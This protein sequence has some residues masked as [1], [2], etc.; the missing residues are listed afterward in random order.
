MKIRSLFE[1]D[2]FRPINGVV[3]AEQQ[4]DAVIWQELEEY[5]VTREL[6]RH[7]RDFFDA[8]VQALRRADDPAIAGN[9]GVWISG[10]FG[11]GK[12]HFLKILSYLLQNR[13]AR[14]DSDGTRRR[15]V[16]FFRDKIADQKL[17]ADILTA[18]NTD[19]D[20]ILFN[21]DS[22]A[23][24]QDGDDAILG[25]FW[26]VFNEMRG[27][28]GEIPYIAAMEE[29]LDG[30][31][32]YD[33]FQQ[34]FQELSGCSWQE[35]RDAFHF[36]RDPLIGALA[37]TLGMTQESAAKWFDDEG[38]SFVASIDNFAKSVAAYIQK[39]GGQRRVIFLVDEVGQFIGSDTRRM[40][41]LQTITENLGTHCRGRAWVIVTSQADIE[42]VLGEVKASKAN[43]FSKIQGR[44]KTRLSLSSSNTDEVIR[45]RLLRKTDA[46]REAL[47]PLYQ[48]KKD[49]LNNQLS[50][51]GDCA[52][53][54]N[55]ASETDFVST[56]PFAPYH[57]QL[58]QKVFE[59]IRKAGA[60]G[61]H[62]S[63]GERSMLDAF[64]SA[65]R[66]VAG[67]EIG[68][69]VPLDAFYPSI[70]SFL[71]TVVKATIDRAAENP[72]LVQPLDSRVLKTLFLIRYVEL[73]KP[74]VDNLV[75]LFVDKV[76]TDRLALKR[77]LQESLQRL[78]KETLINR[79][80]EL[81]YFLTNEERDISRE[82]KREPV[83]AAEQRALLQTLFFD[84]ILKGQTKFRMKDFRRDYEF[85]R[86][87][88]GHPH[89][90]RGEQ[91]MAVEIITQF[92]DD[93]PSLDAARCVLYSSP[94]PGR[95][96]FK[97]A[98]DPLLD[99]E[100]TIWCQTD[101]YI[102]GPKG[103]ADTPVQKRILRERQD[104]NVDRR[105]RLQRRLEK[106]LLQADVYSAGKALSLT[107]QAR[108][109]AKNLLESAFD[110]LVRNLYNEF[111][112]LRSLQ[113]S[114]EKC[115]A[116]IRSVMLS[117]TVGQHALLESLGQVN[118]EA[119][120]A[121][122]DHLRMQSGAVLSL[123]DLQNRFSRKPFGWPEWE[124]VLLVA[125]LYMAGSVNLVLGTAETDNMPPQALLEQLLKTQ[126][127]KTLCITLR[128]KP[129]EA[130]IRKLRALYQE[131]SGK[132]AGN[133]PDEA[134]RD[135]RDLLAQWQRPLGGYADL[136]ASGQYPGAALLEDCR[137][138][139]APLC[140]VRDDA[141]FAR[142]IGKKAD[143][144]RD[145]REDLD[146]LRD[147]FQT[148]KPVWER[149]LAALN[150]YQSSRSSLQKDAQAAEALKKLESIRS[151][152]EP[153][154]LIKDIDGLLA[155]IKEVAA[156]QLAG[157]RQK[158]LDDV[159]GCLAAVRDRLDSLKA[160]DAD[161]NRILHPLQ[162]L[163]Q[164]VTAARTPEEVAY[165]M[166]ELGEQRDKAEEEL[167]ALVHP[168][169]TGTPG[170]DGAPQPKPRRHVKVAQLV[171]H[172]TL[173]NAEDV[174][175]FI[176]ELKVQ[177]LAR[178]DDSTRL[179]VE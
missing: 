29:Y 19:T 153:Y 4:D 157:A 3:K 59:S 23:N 69:L 102:K 159:D 10:F 47:A 16:D 131:L 110:Y 37:H 147:F 15:A 139:L 109:S 40:L 128:H 56:Y 11:S 174:E 43:D 135:F 31:G 49:I 167:D 178:L 98:E 151:Y 33:A 116:E 62:L 93:F 5:V 162:S 133:T 134:V 85:A 100:V 177:L 34:K 26:R 179:V 97:L 9:M 89:A 66:S 18:G 60:T 143:V 165:I 13:E 20:V 88:D 21:I 54:K 95:L 61:S 32:C 67:G 138:V 48:A 63:R 64:Q 68:A 1:K 28:H 129:A 156:A 71:D 81:Y 80:G 170:Q 149:L 121:V 163:R 152:Q 35:N 161:R 104:E 146:T 96:L 2:V 122:E 107:S 84:E 106:L 75:T 142:D 175:R 12:S 86:L 73:I 25:V 113:D 173:E 45:Y 72:G 114:E 76:D 108:S 172:R 154:N 94:Q 118:P 112:R 119:V 38:A 57:F 127:W 141:A 176:T 44:F 36:Y 8:Y 6:D 136:L 99:R 166:L 144:L 79:N 101:K 158:A 27:Y 51:T 145:V 148:Q 130:D 117:N 137:S 77:A 126:A 30:R 160:T 24:M 123:A 90:A 105:Q 53:L 52:T 39:Q 82:I 58:I 115:R 168:A 150:R 125:R 22:R 171:S 55:F 87:L 91:D 140:G 65:I 111:P 164:R 120:K 124:I 132:I 169:G 78:E 14:D 7:F 83:S 46:A 17:M 41:Q 70:E 92:H 42:A 50:F 103:T 74:N 155:C